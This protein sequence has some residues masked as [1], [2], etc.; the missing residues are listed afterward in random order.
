MPD[1]SI[2]EWKQIFALIELLKPF[3]EITQELE[4]DSYPTIS[5]SYPLILKLM[6]L[7]NQFDDQGDI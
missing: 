4:G 6:K 2:E 5:V 7:V 1:I 3:Y